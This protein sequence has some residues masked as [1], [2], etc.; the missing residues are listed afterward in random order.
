M[1]LKNSKKFFVIFL[2]CRPKIT[3]GRQLKIELKKEE[4]KSFK[5]VNLLF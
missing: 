1:L 5:L 3:F 2:Y 4:S